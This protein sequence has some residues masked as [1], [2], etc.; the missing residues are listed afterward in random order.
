MHPPML[1][2]PE[3]PAEILEHIFRE[4]ITPTRAY[5][6]SWAPNPIYPLALVCRSW[7]TAALKLLFVHL[8]LSFP[9]Q[10]ERYFTLVG[11]SSPAQTET[12]TAL[13]R[14]SPEERKSKLELSKLPGIVNLTNLTSITINGGLYSSFGEPRRCL[15]PPTTSFPEGISLPRITSLAV[16]GLPS[17]HTLALISACDRNQLTTLWTDSLEEF[18]TML[19]PEPY[20]V[21]LRHVHLTHSI[22][23]WPDAVVDSVSAA[24]PM[25]ELLELALV[26]SKLLKRMERW[27]READFAH[28]KRFLITVVLTSRTEWINRTEAEVQQ[29][30]AAVAEKGWE[31]SVKVHSGLRTF[32]A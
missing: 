10:L 28:M 3:L 1:P 7:R 15:L 27:I 18:P 26:D 17:A 24:A 12:L 8:R 19:E 22:H 2:A 13:V 32:W 16:L 4:V 20:F 23:T 21:A 14:L 25:M 11:P 31:T 5:S 29:F 9:E 6:Q 30:K